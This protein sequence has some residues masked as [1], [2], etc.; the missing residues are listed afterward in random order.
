VLRAQGAQLSAQAAFATTLGLRADASVAP[1]DDSGVIDESTLPAGT[2]L[3]YGLAV[4]RA[5]ALRPDYLA[6]LAQVESAGEN[7]R[8]NRLGHAPALSLI[9]GGGYQAFGT[10]SEAMSAVDSV[11]ANL[12]VPL[13]DQNLTN[14]S[15]AQAWA[16]S[17][18]SRASLDTTQLQVRA[19]VREA[20]VQLIASQA[21]LD[22]AGDE[23]KK[24]R[25]VVAATQIQYRAGQTSL[26]L[27]LN[28]QTQLS[29]AETDR[30]TALYD[31]RQNEQTYLYALGEND[32]AQT[33]H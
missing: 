27:L 25:D 7:V 9:A 20:L 11:G 30:L 29:S 32:L 31:L 15:V 13:F 14:V 10:A 26:S 17:A 16:Q 12:S 19:D 33:P 1:I 23:L 28:A 2:P 24:A 8:A 21:A 5:L 22:A 6:A 3:D 4:R 18:R